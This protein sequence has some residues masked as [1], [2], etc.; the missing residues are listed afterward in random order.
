LAKGGS[1]SQIADQT[2]ISDKTV[3][4]YRSRIMQKMGLKR[5]AEITMYAVRN[6]LLVS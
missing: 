5:N 4:T 3:S 2:M 1:V 6:N